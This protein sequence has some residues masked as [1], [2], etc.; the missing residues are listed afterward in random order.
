MFE[1]IS[2]GH[3]Y[4]SLPQKKEVLPNSHMDVHKFTLVTLL[5]L[6]HNQEKQTVDLKL[7]HKTLL[8]I[9]EKHL[10]SNC[11]ETRFDDNLHWQ[12]NQGN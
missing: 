10:N 3:Y 6:D 8:L 9:A 11:C 1:E 7:M 5:D 12:R 2:T 4:G